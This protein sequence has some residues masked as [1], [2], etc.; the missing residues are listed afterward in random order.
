MCIS[1]RRHFAPCHAMHVNL[2]Q[3]SKQEME[4]IKK[5]IKSLLETTE[6]LRRKFPH[7]KF[8]LDGRLIG[9]VGEIVAEHLYEIN[10]YEKQEKHYDGTF[11]IDSEKKV[12]IKATMKNSLTYPTHHV[13]QYYL[14]LKIDGD[15]KVETI[16]N[17]PGKV[18]QDYLDKNRK[19]PKSG[20]Y[21]V[22]NQILKTLNAQ[23]A[24]RDRIPNKN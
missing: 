21:S 12:Q 16:F 19:K 4:T 20:L 14:G 8:T 11:K 7:R 10:L 24:N 22:S 17:G 5:S 3:Y 6:I 13:P 1:R 23:I 18:I 15:G 9:D 2:V